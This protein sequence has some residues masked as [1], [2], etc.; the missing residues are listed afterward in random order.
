MKSFWMKKVLCEEN[1]AEIGLTVTDVINHS[2]IQITLR[3]TKLVRLILIKNFFFLWNSGSLTK[4]WLSIDYGVQ[5]F[6]VKRSSL[7]LSF[8]HFLLNGGWTWTPNLRVMRRMFYHCATHAVFQSL[9]KP[10]IFY[11][12]WRWKA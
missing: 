8:S 11:N 12:N 2:W 7:L 6:I 3:Y 5:R 1:S 9:V 10:I 4:G